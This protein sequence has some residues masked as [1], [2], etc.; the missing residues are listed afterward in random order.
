MDEKRSL[1]E[2]VKEFTTIMTTLGQRQVM[3]YMNRTGLSHSQMM[4]IGR[5]YAHGGVGISEM[6]AHMGTTDAAASQLIDRLVNQGF[7]ERN[8]STSDRRKKEVILTAKGRAI[9]ESMGEQREQIVDAILTHVSVEKQ[10]FIAEAMNVILEAAYKVQEQMD[11]D[12]TRNPS[13]S[14]DCLKMPPTG[15]SSRPSKA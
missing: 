8:E 4:T 13:G 3:Q 15:I 6:S 2:I 7:V 12:L 9:I 1:K 14:E 11:L 5:L 10:A